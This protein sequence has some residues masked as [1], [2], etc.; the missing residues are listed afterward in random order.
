MG[1]SRDRAMQETP[2]TVSIILPTYNRARFLPQALSSIRD[3]QFSDWELIVVDDGSTDETRDVVPRLTAEFAQP[4]RY[5]YQENQGAYGARNTGLDHARGKYIAFYDSDD[6]WLPHHLADCVQALE[7][8]PEVDWVYGAC[9]MMNESTGEI[10]AENTFYVDGKPRPFLSLKNQAAGSLRIVNDGNVLVAMIEHGLYNGLQ[11]SLLRATLFDGMRFE[12]DARN[13]AEDQLVVI[14]V[15]AKG[16]RLAYFDNVH[17]IY[18]V[19]ESNSSAAGS[20]GD[21]SR[22]QRVIGLMIA[23]YEKLLREGDWSPV[24]RRALRRRLARECFWCQGYATL[25]QSG[26]RQDAIKM[27]RRGL[28]YWPWGWQYWKTYAACNVRMLLRSCFS[29][30]IQ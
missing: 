3:Q 25:W 23:G 18:R 30:G 9:R 7:A 4:V 27:F 11:N 13:E 22:Q 5:I 21:L 15:L 20:G 1:S 24:V 29:G 12:H 19:H 28:M 17:V 8:H 26:Q 2:R 6:V 14:R 16:H 10:I